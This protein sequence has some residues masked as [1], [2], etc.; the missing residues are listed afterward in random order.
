MNPTD[1]L[2]L[3]GPEGLELTLAPFG[4]TWRSCRVPLADG[5]VREV[6]LGCE[7]LHDPRCRQAYLGA[8]VGRYANRIRFG[9]IARGG[10]EWQ[11]ACQSGSAHQLHGGPDGF[12][13]RPWQVIE[14][15][16]D[17]V[18]FALE[19]PHGDQGYPG[20]LQVQL[21]Y[22]LLPGQAIEMS[23]EA[24]TDAPTPVCIT[25][26]SYFNLDAEHRDV[27][28]HRLAIDAAQ[29]LPVDDALIPFGG[30]SGV[31]GTGFD[32]RESRRIAEHWLQ[33]AQQRASHGYDHAWLLAPR[34][35]DMRLPA[36]RLRSADGRLAMALHTTLPALQFY[37]GQMLAGTPRRGGGT[38]EACNGLALEPQFLPDSPNHPEWPQPDCWLLPGQTYRQVMRWRFESTPA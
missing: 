22:R 12:D 38:Y 18:V 33:D 21:S 8:T 20:R 35:A 32:F 13:R 31:G 9:R 30:L 25:Q 27:R 34:C 6:L 17:G 1:T 4:A 3:R 5:S 23:C 28:E 19:S 26:H 10:S 24:R 15:S 37:S 14:Q 16:D 29:W 2:R 7:D 11:L 36:A